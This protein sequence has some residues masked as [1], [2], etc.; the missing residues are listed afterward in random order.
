[1]QGVPLTLAIVATSFELLSYTVYVRDI[2]SRR[3]RPSRASWIVWA[4]LGWLT[5]ASN[6]QAG[7]DLTLI[8]LSAMCLG[9]TAVAVLSLRFGTG[10]WSRIDRLC[11]MLT[12]IGIVLWLQ[13]RD[14]VTALLFFILADVSAALPTIRDAMLQPAKDSRAAWSLGLVAAALNLVVVQPDHWSLSWAGFGVWSFNVYLL[15]LNALVVGLMFRPSLRQMLCPGGRWALRGG[16]TF[17]TPA[18]SRKAS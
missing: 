12:A 14:P 13:T 4:P 16:G 15:L 18:A 11:F 1:M 10:G 9:V 6:W 5:L 7:A 2:V 17:M 3:A 8:K